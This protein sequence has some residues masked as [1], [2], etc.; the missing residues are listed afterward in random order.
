[1]MK[2]GSCGS[3]ITAQEKFKTTRDGDRRRYVY[4]HCSRSIDKECKEPYIREELLIE[5]LVGVLDSIEIDHSVSRKKFLEEMERYQK[6]LTSVLGRDEKLKVPRL[7]H[8]SYIRHVLTNG[9]KEE[10]RE[11]LFCMKS[12]LRLSQKLVVIAP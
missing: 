11:L 10:K 1:M 8:R 3:G 9:S 6:F 7:D 12:E 5:Q 2:C 4:Y